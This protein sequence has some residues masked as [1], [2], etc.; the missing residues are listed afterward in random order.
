MTCNVLCSTSQKVKGAKALLN[1]TPALHSKSKASWMPSTSIEDWLVDHEKE[2]RGPRETPIL[3]SKDNT[4]SRHTFYGQC[5]HFLRHRRHSPEHTSDIEVGDQSN[6]STQRKASCTYN[7]WCCWMRIR[8]W[9]APKIPDHPDKSSCIV[10]WKRRPPTYRQRPGMTHLLNRKPGC[11]AKRIELVI[12][13][14]RCRRFPPKS[15]SVSNNVAGRVLAVSYQTRQ[16]SAKLWRTADI[17][18]PWPRVL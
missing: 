2:R 13:K 1:R 4:R 9:K 10:R 14:T 3:R 17:G 15:I 7:S 8:I 5:L 11:G 18:A 16:G 6:N 12:P